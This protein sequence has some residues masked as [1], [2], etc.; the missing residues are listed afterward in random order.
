MFFKISRRHH[1]TAEDTLSEAAG[2]ALHLGFNSFDNV[3]IASMRNM[4]VAPR[5]MLAGRSTRRVEKRR[6]CDENKRTLGGRFA[7]RRPLGF[8]DLLK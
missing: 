7:P 2:E 5:S 6:L 4:A 8:N 1:R 3:L